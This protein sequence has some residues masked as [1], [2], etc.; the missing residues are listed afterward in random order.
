MKTI[1]VVPHTVRRNVD[2]GREISI[3]SAY[4]PGNWETVHTGYTWKVTDRHGRST[5]GLGRKPVPTLS[6]ANEVADKFCNTIPNTKN[7]SQLT[8]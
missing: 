6:E 2:T 8:H 7:I 4:T 3:F 5:F 1:E